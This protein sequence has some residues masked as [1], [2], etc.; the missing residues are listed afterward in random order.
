M[1][2]KHL[3][4]KILGSTFPE[5]LI[6]LSTSKPRRDQI[7]CVTLHFFPRDLH[8]QVEGQRLK[9]HLIES[10][11]WATQA[12]VLRPSKSLQVG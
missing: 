3:Q 7:N 5:K 4:N 12:W 11:G 10:N 8:S 9:F 6:R 1:G 2:S